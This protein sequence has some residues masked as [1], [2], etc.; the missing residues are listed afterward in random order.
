MMNTIAWNNPTNMDLFQKFLARIQNFL[1]TRGPDVKV[2]TQ[3]LTPQVTGIGG[4]LMNFDTGQILSNA[5][6]GIPEEGAITLRVT[7]PDR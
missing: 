7:I 2:L 1:D 5:L 4:A 3:A 6:S